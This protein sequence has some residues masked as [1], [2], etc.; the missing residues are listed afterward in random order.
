MNEGWKNE[1]V[2]AGVHN[3]KISSKELTSILG[4]DN[5]E[6]IWDT[7]ELNYTESRHGASYI[8]WSLRDLRLNGSQCLL[9]FYEG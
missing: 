7:W 4:Q 9:Q 2:S 6:N 3:L 8:C 5:E 1:G